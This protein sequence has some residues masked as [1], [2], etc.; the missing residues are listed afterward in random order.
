MQAGARQSQG[1]LR[2]GCIGTRNDMNK[3]VTVSRS[4]C[5]IL[6]EAKDLVTLRTNSAKSLTLTL[7]L[8]HRGRGERESCC[9]VI[10]GPQS[11]LSL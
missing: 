2:P 11:L 1:L 6:S 4:I 8:S 5:V 10:A 3:G 9:F 7:L